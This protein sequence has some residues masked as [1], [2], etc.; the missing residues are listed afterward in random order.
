MLLF[1]HGRAIPRLVFPQFF[2]TRTA[3]QLFGDPHNV[4]HNEGKARNFNISAFRGNVFSAGI[5]SNQSCLFRFNTY[6]TLYCI[7]YALIGQFLVLIPSVLRGIS[8]TFAIPTTQFLHIQSS[9]FRNSSN[10]WYQC[11][12]NRIKPKVLPIKQI[13]PNQLMEL[14]TRHL[15]I[16]FFQC[17]KTT[18]RRNWRIK[19]SR[20]K[21]S[22]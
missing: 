9:V 18:L 16:R 14:A 20:S 17:L 11:P 3:G 5:R 13:R 7:F 6:R 12:T 15:L 8:F 19:G 1:S 22:R 4:L 2:T 21:D 10:L